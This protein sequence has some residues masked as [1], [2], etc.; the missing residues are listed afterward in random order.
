MYEAT[1]SP[2]H[3]S[4]SL[5]DRCFVQLYLLRL[6]A[7]FAWSVG[8]PA[9]VKSKQTYSPPNELLFQR[10]ISHLRH[11]CRLGRGG[12][13]GEAAVVRRCCEGDRAKSLN[14]KASSLVFDTRLGGAD[15][16]P[17]ACLRGHSLQPCWSSY[18]GARVPLFFC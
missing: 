1:D 17:D 16:S 11:D 9:F 3:C 7:S 15:D 5:P 14:N 8:V 13:R 4:S 12:G 2:R 10:S 18:S 6:N